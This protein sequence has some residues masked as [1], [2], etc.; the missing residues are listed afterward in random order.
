MLLNVDLSRIGQTISWWHTYLWNYIAISEGQDRW[1][2]SPLKP[3]ICT[4]GLV[5]LVVTTDVYD[6]CLPRA[7]IHIYN[8]NWEHTFRT[9]PPWHQTV[10]NPYIIRSEEDNA[11]A[12]VKGSGPQDM[13]SD[14]FLTFV[15]ESTP[16]AWLFH[17]GTVGFIYCSS[18]G[19][20]AVGINATVRQASIQMI[21][22]ENGTNEYMITV[23][24]PWNVYIVHGCSLICTLHYV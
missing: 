20:C 18:S 9:W 16:C 5:K 11:S 12:K 14:T 2:G 15:V 7:L 22:I 19:L 4:N 1:A 17:S 21:R 8:S 13:S 6:N 23:T 24:G 10:N 3:I